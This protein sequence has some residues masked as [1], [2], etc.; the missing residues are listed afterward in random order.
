MPGPTATIYFGL[1]GFVVLWIIAIVA[2]F[3]F[4]H[5]VLHWVGILRM[6]RPERRWDQVPKR[7]GYVLKNVFGQRR[8][9]KEPAFGLAHFFIF[10]TF[11]FYAGSFFWNL[12]R[13]LFPFLPLPYADDIP[14]IAFIRVCKK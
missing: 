2:F 7:L 13:G 5:R 11:V 6:A 9:L 10:W 3:L 14:V 1:P 8:L 12:V 4:V